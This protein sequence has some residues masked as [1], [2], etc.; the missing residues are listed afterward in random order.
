MNKKTMLPMTALIAACMLMACGKAK[1]DTGIENHVTERTTVTVED[2]TNKIAE[3]VDVTQNQE[4]AIND[5]YKEKEQRIIK[6]VDMAHCIGESFVTFIDWDP[7][8]VMALD[9]C[10]S[11]D[12]FYGNPNRNI[13][14]GGLNNVYLSTKR[15]SKNQYKIY[16][17]ENTC[18]E[19]AC[20][21]S[22]EFINAS[23]INN[24][25]EREPV[26]SI[27][28]DY[29]I[30]TEEPVQK[31]RW[32]VAYS[33]GYL[34]RASRGNTW[35]LPVYA[36]TLL[37]S[38]V[39]VLGGVNGCWGVNFIYVATT[40]DE[41]DEEEVLKK[42]DYLAENTYLVDY[43]GAYPIATDTTAYDST[44]IEMKD[45]DEI[46]ASWNNLDNDKVY[47][48][49]E[50]TNSPASEREQ[51]AEEK[52][53]EMGFNFPVAGYDSVVY[54]DDNKLY[55]TIEAS[56]ESWSIW[57]EYD[58]LRI[59]ASESGIEADNLLKLGEIQLDGGAWS[60][61]AD[62]INYEHVAGE[63]MSGDYRLVLKNGQYTIDMT[64]APNTFGTDK[65]VTIQELLERGLD[66]IY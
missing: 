56:E 41:P 7:S 28:I 22:V 47:E 34:E 16:L 10:F 3:P 8:K 20:M 55:K 35:K 53:H 61:Y 57:I 48:K 15:D 45:T 2:I 25:A 18:G 4:T 29:Q 62:S 64:S 60:V 17:F 46:V 39:R 1:V 40:E 63:G 12:S 49:K 52:L 50:Q 27:V 51:F 24:I 58:N 66:A 13:R 59:C 26:D 38:D 42:L 31:G 65:T 44:W 33:H 11:E 43:F 23:V 32:E 37:S 30:Y 9:D 21:E 6:G 5:E 36:Y 14:N 54:W 19:Y